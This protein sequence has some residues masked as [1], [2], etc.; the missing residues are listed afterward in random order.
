MTL[1]YLSSFSE[2]VT[3]VKYK[4]RVYDV[5]NGTSRCRG[6]I[7]LASNITYVSNRKLAALVDYTEH[8][9]CQIKTER[10]IGYS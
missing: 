4:L 1:R 6:Y 9:I 7:S 3:T 2:F 5:S 10:T 8:S